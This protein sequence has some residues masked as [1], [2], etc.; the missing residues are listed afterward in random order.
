MPGPISE[1]YNPAP[2]GQEEDPRYGIV[3]DCDLKSNGPNY[4]SA[5]LVGEIERLRR[6]LDRCWAAAGLA[7]VKKTGMMF[8]AW[9]E[10]SPLVASIEDNR[11]DA[12]ELRTKEAEEWNG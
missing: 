2:D 12:D 6:L 9:E 11:S 10:C 3:C 7:R 1:S 8:Q 4:D 5:T